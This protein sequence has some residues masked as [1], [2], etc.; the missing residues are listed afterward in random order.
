MCGRSCTTN[1]LS[2]FENIT[3]ELDSGKVIDVIY[4]DF[5]KA[6]NTVPHERLKK[7]LKAHSIDGDVLKWIM[8]WLSGRKQRV[9]LNGKELS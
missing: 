1:L 4:L 8:A 3:A 6:F 5:A 2:F 9:V 7:K